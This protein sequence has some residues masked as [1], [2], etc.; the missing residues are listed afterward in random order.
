MSPQQ[1][2]E[3]RLTNINKSLYMSDIDT[4]ALKTTLTLASNCEFEA[5][6][7][8][9]WEW[10]DFRPTSFATPFATRPSP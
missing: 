3:F 8:E 10:I 9:T 6:T 5:I 4:N 2:P 7:L 1:A